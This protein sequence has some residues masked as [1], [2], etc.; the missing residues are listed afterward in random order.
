M[1]DSTKCPA[2][3]LRPEANRFFRWSSDVVAVKRTLAVLNHHETS[4]LRQGLEK[5]LAKLEANPPL[6]V[7]PAPFRDFEATLK[8]DQDGGTLIEALEEGGWTVRS[9]RLE[10]RAKGD[11]WVVTFFG[12]EELAEE[13]AKLPTVARVKATLAAE[14]VMNGGVGCLGEGCPDCARLKGA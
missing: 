14:P 6:R 2:P 13:V 12:S 5:L 7:S 3:S 9:R 4:T 10:E 8:E 1:T 11:R